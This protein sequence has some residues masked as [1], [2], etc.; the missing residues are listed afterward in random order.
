MGAT[1]EPP[2]ITI[3]SPEDEAWFEPGS[4]FKITADV[5]DDREVIDVELYLDGERLFRITEPP[6]EWQVNDIP[7]GNYLF[8]AVARDSRNATP[9]N[10]IDVI[11]S[12]EPP[13]PDDTGG[14]TGPDTGTTGP[15]E[16][17]GEP[18]PEPESDTDGDSSGAL[19][20]KG[21]GCRSSGGAAPWLLLLLLPFV[22]RRSVGVFG[23]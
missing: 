3:T 17:T 6:W 22:R 9:S 1:D 14:S 10:A 12:D 8:G 23:P 20:D 11:V 15:A 13:P 4:S 7:E 21:C 18:E 5:A 16:T 2:T 19:D